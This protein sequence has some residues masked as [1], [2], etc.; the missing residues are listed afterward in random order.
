[1]RAVFWLAL[2]MFSSGVGVKPALA[3]LGY[4]ARMTCSVGLSEL[5][6]SSPESPTATI[7]SSAVAKVLDAQNRVFFGTE[8]VSEHDLRNQARGTPVDHDIIQSAGEAHTYVRGDVPRGFAYEAEVNAFTHPEPLSTTCSRL[9]LVESALPPPEDP[10]DGPIVQGCAPGCG[11]PIVIDLDQRGYKFTNI[12]DGV[13][14]DLTPGGMIERVAWT[15][16]GGG[17]AFLA[18]DRS[19]NGSIDDGT[20]LFGDSTPQPPSAAPNGYRALAVF[21]TLAAGGDGDG[22]ITAVDS[23]FGALRLWIDRNHDG[24]AQSDELSTLASQDVVSI[25]LDYVESRRR[26]RHGNELRYASVV[27]RTGDTT[28]AVD[29][30]LL[31]R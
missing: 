24:V 15:S 8:V 3:Q 22:Q 16:I 2:F 27:Q 20:E 23:I 11:S 26:D 13:F 18:L 21:D 29:V 14:F 7:H 19:G 6:G 9:L 28:Q 4:A 17:D 5:G 12:D 31:Q 1:M 30:F 25:S 10:T